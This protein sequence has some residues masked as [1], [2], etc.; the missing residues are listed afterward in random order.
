M[1]CLKVVSKTKYVTFTDLHHDLT[2]LANVIETSKLK[3]S[4]YQ[5]FYFLLKITIRS[6]ISAAVDGKIEK[7]QHY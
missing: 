3:E 4:V 6:K 2:S 1:L 5:T 7:K